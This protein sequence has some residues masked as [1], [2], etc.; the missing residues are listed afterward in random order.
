MTSGDIRDA[1]AYTFPAAARHLGIPTATLR[2][3]V[4]GRTFR[5][6]GE[7]VVTEPLIRAPAGKSNLISFNNL[8]PGAR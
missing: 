8:L 5:R 4:L 6:G 3:W 2:S 1:P 7:V